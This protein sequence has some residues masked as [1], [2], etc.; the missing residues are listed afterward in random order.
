MSLALKHQDRSQRT[1]RVGAGKVSQVL[2]QRSSV[3]GQDMLQRKEGQCACGGGCPGCQS[4]LPVQTKLSISE[5]GDI[6]EQEADRVAD[7]V[8]RMP[9]PA[10]ERSSINSTP[11]RA[12]SLQRKCATCEDE[13]LQR[14]SHN[15]NAATPSSGLDT[16]S[17]TLR[18]SGS[19]LDANTRAFFEPRFGVDFSAVRIH[20][21]TQAAESARSVNALAYTVGRDV[22]FN[23]SQYAPHT[24]SGKRLLAH[25]LTHVVQQGSL[26]AHADT[27]VRSRF[28]TPAKNVGESQLPITYPVTHQVQRQ[29]D[30]GGPYH[31]PEG[32][33]L[34]CT[35][36]D[37][38]SSLSLKINY[39]RHTIRRHIEWDIANP[40]P[41]YP[42]GRHA[43]EIMELTNGLANCIELHQIRCTR[44]PEVVPVP[45]P[46]PVPDPA[47]VRRVATAAAVGAG[48][49]VVVGAII[50]AVGG[51][52]GGTLVAPGVGTIG[53]GVAGGVAG[54]AEGGAIGGIVG[55]AVM[56]GAQALWE[57]LSD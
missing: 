24:D 31:P 9:D 27:F 7:Q 54:A 56:G 15:S 4:G 28:T 19:P 32:T 51:G 17:A 39:L 11:I 18:Q 46:L 49:G 42:G 6:Y 1:V 40:N 53:V 55:G 25:E 43:Q 33:S 10:L 30:P 37:S 38:C 36:A 5:P 50:G 48:I 3:P 26:A 2:V 41:A 34:R 13:E 22:A 16:V 57:W 23:S 45:V 21:D 47:A 29:H 12:L 44:Q 14:K 35:A 52:A 8:M 20:T